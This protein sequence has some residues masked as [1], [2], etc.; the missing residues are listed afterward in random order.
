MSSSGYELAAHGFTM[1]LSE[2]GTIPLDSSK[3]SYNLCIDAA[4][5]CDF[6]IAIIDGRFGGEVPGT[7]KSITLAEIE[8]ALDAGKQVRVFVRA[9]GMGCEGGTAALFQRQYQVSTI[10][11]DQRQTRIRRNRLY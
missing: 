9:G 10:Q 7:G 8:A 5:K 6:L 1:L 11:A 2:E 3:H 4:K